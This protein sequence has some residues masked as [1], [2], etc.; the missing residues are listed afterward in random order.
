MPKWFSS[1]KNIKNKLAVGIDFGTTMSRV[2]YVVPGST[3]IPP[4]IPSVPSV[5]SASRDPDL[6][7]RLQWSVGEGAFLHHNVS[8]I[9]LN[10]GAGMPIYKIED[11]RLR[12]NDELNDVRPEVLAARIIYVLKQKAQKF[13]NSVKD[14]NEVTISV[15]AEW[16]ILN[17]SATIFAAKIAGFQRVN[18]IEEPIA[19]YLAIQQFKKDNIAKARKILVFDCGGGTLDV[20]IIINEPGKLPFAAGRST[21]QNVAGENI[22]DKLSK[23]ILGESEWTK[24]DQLIEQRDL[25]R[26]VKKLKEVLNPIAIAD[27]PI[28]EAKRNERTNIGHLRDYQLILTLEKHNQVV[29][30]I[31]SHGK[32][33]L[34][35]ALASCY[36]DGEHVELSP[37]DIDRVILVGGSTYL[38][39]LQ[40]MVKEYFRKEISDDQIIF[41]RPEDLVAI[42]AALWQSYI[43]NG[44]ELFQ[45]TLSMKT[46]L[47]AK[48]WDE[49][50][51][52]LID[53]E[54]VL[55]KPGDE[56]PKVVSKS[57]GIKVQYVP[58]PKGIDQLSWKVYQSF[59][60]SEKEK[61]PVGWI[62]YSG[63]ISNW[64]QI[65]LDYVIGKNGI[66]EKWNPSF[67]IR[68]DNNLTPEFNSYYDWASEDPDEIAR[69][70]SVR[71]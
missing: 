35:L 8:R 51:R 18:L 20:T 17:R 61:I 31:I 66:I 47:L 21:D 62:N 57:K 55:G 39:P 63:Q 45:P 40:K 67:M 28:A 3:F 25:A 69:K 9:K 27:S 36:I 46:Y 4:D 13:D 19:A 6:L 23:E 41:F 24:L 68:Q 5:V 38:R 16:S 43:Q 70:F 48:E 59:A 52:E 29:Q 15:P 58:V 26:Q 2:T 22:D 53:R 44:E 49:R 7:S 42:G 10:I 60:Y 12:P 64:D 37:G 11:H 14:I 56:L 1:G 54:Y 32:E 71:Y 34:D 65:I 50:G 33:Q 30:K